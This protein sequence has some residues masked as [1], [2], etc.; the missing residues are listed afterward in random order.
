MKA[1][2]KMVDLRGGLENLDADGRM[3]THLSTWVP[4]FGL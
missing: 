4:F 1:L 3:K 2:K